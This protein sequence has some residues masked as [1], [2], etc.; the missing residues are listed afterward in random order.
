MLVSVVKHYAAKA[1]VTGNI[2][3]SEQPNAESGAFAAFSLKT[4]GYEI[5]VDEK[6]G[7]LNHSA[8]QAYNMIN[9]FAHE[10]EHDVNRKTQY[11][12]Y[13]IDAILAQIKHSSFDKTDD[14]FKASQGTYAATLL[15]QAI[16]QGVGL[17]NI[18]K[19]IEEVNKSKLG[20]FITL[21]YDENQKKVISTKAMEE[22]IIKSKPDPK[23]KKPKPNN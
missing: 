9:S 7:K 10:K 20:K 15:N 16:S 18:K 6:T 5:I 11:P 1:S 13:H 2:T 21:S 19:R 22:V 4:N 8:G 3:V 23:K 17:T 14:E 12:Y